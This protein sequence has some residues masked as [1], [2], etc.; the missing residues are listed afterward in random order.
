MRRLLPILFVIA[1]AACSEPP[2][3]ELDQ[4]QGAIDAARAAGAEQYAKDEYGAATTSLQKARDAVDQRDYRQAL[5]YALDA[6]ERAQDA[7]RAAADGKAAAR[8]KAESSI[9]ALSSGVT[10][11]DARLK[12]AEA[13]RVPIRELRDA[14]V[15]EQSARNA[16]Q[17]AGTALA[18]GDYKAATDAVDGQTARV[19]TAI[20]ELETAPSRVA[21]RKR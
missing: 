5:S 17:E 1:A 10:Q 21:R 6:R 20:K 16:L 15:V 19:Q 13:A 12:A 4:A 9:I 7:A 18:K 3:K 14:R 11:L 8:S 2:Q